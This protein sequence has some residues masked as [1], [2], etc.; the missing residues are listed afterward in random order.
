MK[1]PSSVGVL[2]GIHATTIFATTRLGRIWGFATTCGNTS[3]PLPSNHPP[4]GTSP[5]H[6]ET[7]IYDMEHRSEF[8]RR[9]NLTPRCVVWGLAEVEAWIDEREQR[10]R[11]GRSSTAP[12]PDMSQRITRPV[13]SRNQRA[14]GYAVS[15]SV[16]FCPLTG[17]RIASLA[18]LI[19]SATLAASNIPLSIR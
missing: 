17:C 9:F 10:P 13:R 14:D 4:A 5:N 16:L 1:P 3:A 7:T 15:N 12:G 11:S 8:P 2:Y 18:T 6:P 19:S